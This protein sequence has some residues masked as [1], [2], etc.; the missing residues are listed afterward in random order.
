[1]KKDYK[2]EY[3]KLLA[4]LQEIME[5]V[6]P[7]VDWKERNYQFSEEYCDADAISEIYE[8]VAARAKKKRPKFIIKA[9]DKQFKWYDYF[10]HT[11]DKDAIF[12]GV[13]KEGKLITGKIYR[14]YGDL[15]AVVNQTEHWGSARKVIELKGLTERDLIQDISKAMA[16]K[17]ECTHYWQI[18][19]TEIYMLNEDPKLVLM[20]RTLTLAPTEG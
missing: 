9:G 18:L 12:I 20:N 13:S 1:M 3:N 8:V 17:L 14:T 7:D 4:T 11:A 16:K 2:K 5:T 10:E 15:M 19:G 6:L